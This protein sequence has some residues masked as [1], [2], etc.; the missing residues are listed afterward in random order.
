MCKD[1]A[2]AKVS[3]GRGAKQEVIKMLLGTGGKAQK[4]PAKYLL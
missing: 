4:R 3:G 2:L 1:G